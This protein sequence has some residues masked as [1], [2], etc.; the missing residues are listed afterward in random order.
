MAESTWAPFED[1]LLWVLFLGAH[2]AARHVQRPWF[3]REIA[4]IAAILKL[5]NWE[6]AVA[7]LAPCPYLDYIHWA[8]F[9]AIWEESQVQ[10]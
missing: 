8:T 2:A 9:M 7:L 4:R 6:E 5:R 3:T 1:V 10:G